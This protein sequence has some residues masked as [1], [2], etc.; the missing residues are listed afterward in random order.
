M[1]VAIDTTILLDILRPNPDFVDCSLALVETKAATERLVVCEIV[2]A[3]LAANFAIQQQLDALLA[4]IPAQVEQI[5]RAASF[6]AGRAW[7][8][9]RNAGG[10]R[11]RILPDFMIGAHA[12]QQARMLLSRD[13]G[14]Y[15]TY[16][17]ALEVIS[18]V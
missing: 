14:F 6:A 2:Y 8:D 12:Q 13:R 15:Q 16:F 11:E 10:T 7:R 9:Y 1:T 3:E 5:G 18:S 4:H 17:A